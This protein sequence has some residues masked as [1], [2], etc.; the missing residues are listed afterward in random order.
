MGA[1]ENGSGVKGRGMGGDGREVGVGEG[2]ESRSPDRKILPAPLLVRT[3]TYKTS[4]CRHYLS[5][6]SWGEPWWNPCHS[7]IFDYLSISVE[8]KT[9]NLGYPENHG[10]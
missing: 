6:A 4:I 7:L 1:G 3:V 10:C 9:A 8:G 2:K 5:L